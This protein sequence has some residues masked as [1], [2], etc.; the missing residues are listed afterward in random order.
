MISSEVQ[1]TL[2]KSPP[3]LWTELSDPEALARH[4]NDFG[5][6]RI[7]RVEPE[8]TVE[9]EA[10]S[11]S[12]SVCI[13]ASGWGTR[14]TLRATR[15]KPEPEAAPD[16]DPATPPQASE[17]PA[18]ANP[19]STVA[20]GSAPPE[21]PARA[22]TPE[23]PPRAE[24]P[25]MPDVSDV[26]AGPGV[27]Y[28]PAVPD[29]PEADA[30]AAA[31]TP[32]PAEA[33]AQWQAQAFGESEPEPGREPEIEPALELEPQLRRGLLSR[34]FGWRLNRAATATPAATPEQLVE[35]ELGSQEPAGSV[36]APLVWA[37]SGTEPQATEAS[38][39]DLAG[40]G[41][42]S[43]TP[44]DEAPLLDPLDT[45]EPEPLDTA[46]PASPGAAEPEPAVAAEPEPPAA[47]SEPDISAELAAAEETAAEE[48]RAV[49]TSMLDRLGTA[50]HRPFS[51][52]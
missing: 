48:V 27:P 3:E 10:D 45:A 16:P 17:P 20:A 18:V 44:P 42:A 31:P 1:R 52:A 23:V 15:E 40:G 37:A 39:Q 26:S 47:E 11:A 24:A 22:A 49:L 30:S 8:T 35:P 28:A 6:I 46:E 34:I 32:A 13:K 12:G 14:V 41:P 21:D 19:E 7:T 43:A 4:L 33:L 36:P 50:H 38:R 5:V 9:W 2:V 51:R 29:A 25:G